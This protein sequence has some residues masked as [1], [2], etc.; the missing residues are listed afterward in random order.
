MRNILLHYTV[1]FETL[2]LSPLTECEYLERYL[3]KR[4]KTLAVPIET[5]RLALRYAE[6]QL[7]YSDRVLLNLGVSQ[8]RIFAKFGYQSLHCV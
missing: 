3:R 5:R 7:A 8:N 1:W 2:S 6:F 4:G